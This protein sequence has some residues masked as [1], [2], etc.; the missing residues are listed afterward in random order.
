MGKFEDHNLEVYLDG[1]V[2][3]SYTRTTDLYSVEK[4]II[5]NLRKEVKEGDRILDIGVGTGRT[6]PYLRQLS[7]NYIGVDYSKAMVDSAKKNFP[8]AEFSEEDAR[9]LSKYKDEEFDLVFFSFNGIDYIAHDDRLKA[10][11]EIARVL[12]RGKLF[13]FSTHNIHYRHFDKLRFTYRGDIVRRAYYAFQNTINRLQNKKDHVYTNEYAIVTDPGHGYRLLTY[14]ISPEAQLKQLA[15]KGFS[16]TSLF[17]LKG[18][19]VSSSQISQ[20]SSWLYYQTRKA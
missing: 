6:T 11:S 14:Y 16:N 1:K 4:I 5:D 15:D 10:I 12:K 18:Q 3:S 17:D 19:T 7:S 9:D 2:V 13:V 20:D 8:E